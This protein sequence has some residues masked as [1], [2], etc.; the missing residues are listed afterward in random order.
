MTIISFIAVT[1][2]SLTEAVIMRLSYSIFFSFFFLFAAEL[3]VGFPLSRILFLSLQCSFKKLHL[4]KFLN[5]RERV[6]LL[7]QQWGVVL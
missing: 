2:Y 4:Q 5:V 7:I 1:I 3:S 6:I